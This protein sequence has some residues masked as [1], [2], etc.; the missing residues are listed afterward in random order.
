M[1]ERLWRY[2]NQ[3]LARYN[4]PVL[5]SLINLKRGRPGV[6]LKTRENDLVRISGVSDT[7]SFGLAACQAS[8]YLAR[9]EPLPGPSRL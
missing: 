3:I 6:C 5:T 4:M 7:S 2:R 9:P 1:E 8:D